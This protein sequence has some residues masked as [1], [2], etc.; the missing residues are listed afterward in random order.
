[1]VAHG[2]LWW[3][4]KQKWTCPV[5]GHPLEARNLDL[6][7][8]RVP[9]RGGAKHVTVWYSE[10]YYGDRCQKPMGIHPARY[11]VRIRYS[12][13]ILGG[14]HLRASN[15]GGNSGLVFGTIF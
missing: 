7:V 9:G 10:Y 1:M 14:G 12:E 8:Q 13:G 3:V 11:L 6:V 5:L 15:P 2:K 4:R